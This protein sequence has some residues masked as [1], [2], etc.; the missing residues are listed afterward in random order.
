MIERKHDN[1]ADALERHIDSGHFGAVGLVLL[2]DM[3]IIGNAE[4]HLTED[5]GNRITFVDRKTGSLRG[6]VELATGRPRRQYPCPEFPVPLHFARA[7]R[8]RSRPF[9]QTERHVLAG[10]A[11]LAASGVGLFPGHERHRARPRQR[12][13]SA[14]CSRRTAAP[15]TSR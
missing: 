14:T 15:T 12:T 6:A 4:S 2:K 11:A 13:A 7:D 5:G 10:A 8:R 1:T 3:F 9:A